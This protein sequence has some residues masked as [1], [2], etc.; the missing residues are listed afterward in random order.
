MEE[1]VLAAPT[2][3]LERPDYDAVKPD[4]EIEESQSIFDV[5][6]QM[7]A[8]D[9]DNADKWRVKTVDGTRTATVQDDDFLGRVAAGLAIRKSDIF[10][11]RVREDTI[12]KNGR[13]SRKWTVLKVESFRRGAHD[14]D[15]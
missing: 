3:T 1:E 11:L 13:T 8:I 6:A 5:E 12:E 14:G 2:F 4:D 10:R 7:S 9:F 15:G